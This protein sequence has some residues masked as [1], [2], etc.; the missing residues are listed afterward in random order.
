M[1]KGHV[2]SGYLSRAACRGRR[3]VPFSNYNGY[4][5]PVLLGRLLQDRGVARFIVAPDGYGKTSLAVEYAETMFSWT[6]VFW[7]AAQSPCFIRDLDSGDMA[8]AIAACDDK[9]A[10]AVFDD[11]PALS[12]ARAKAFSAVLDTLMKAGCEVLVTCRPACDTLAGLQRDRILL[13]ARDLL[14]DDD[15][16]DAARSADERLRQPSPQVTAVGRIPCLVWP[17]EGP[18]ARQQAHERFAGQALDDDL[19]NDFLLVVASCLVLGQGSREQLRPFAPMTDE[20]LEELLEDCPHVSFDSAFDRFETPAIAIDDLAV[21]LKKRLS[22]IARQS[23]FESSER[24]VCAWADALVARGNSDRACD[25]VRAAYP[26]N[27]N[28]D[29]LV[30]HAEELVRQACFMP[31]YRLLQL[32][33]RPKGENKRKLHALETL[34]RRML[35]DPEGALRRAKLCAFDEGAS[36]DVRVIGLVTVVKDG[37]GALDERAYSELERIAGLNAGSV[38]GKW[39]LLAQAQCNNRQGT[40]ALARWWRERQRTGTDASV[41]CIAAAWL[42]EGMGPTPEI[43]EQGCASAVRSCE[44]YVRERVAELSQRGLDFFTASAGLAVEEAHQRGMR[45]EGGPLEAASLM[46]LRDVEL[47]VLAQRRQFDEQ[48]RADQLARSDWAFGHPD[49]LLVRE[50]PAWDFKRERNVPILTLRLFGCFDASIG[51][52]PID[53]RLFSRRNTRSLLVVLAM[54]AGREVA[55]DAVVSAM[56][57]GRSLESGKKNF[58]AVWSNLRDALSLPD[59]TCPYLQRHQFGCSLDGNY[60]RS[61]VARL[62]EI[63]RELLFGVPDV[64]HWSMLFAEL[65]RDYSYELMPSERKNPL[66]N[67]ARIDYRNRI[68]DALVSATASIIDAGTPQWGIW[69]ARAALKHDDTREDAYVALMRAQIASNQRTAAMATFLKCRQVL[70]DRLGIDP[71]AEARDLYDSL[72]E[73]R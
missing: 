33:T 25:L 40:A 20:Q 59:G 10:L 19:P 66:V 64:G 48:L 9:A 17:S 11:V 23:P 7:L 37:G 12:P 67:Q 46:A 13:S 22:Q 4:A 3:P 31:V 36:I 21:A 32:N 38:D 69:F 34:C 51:G 72:L 58:Y 15:E 53:K 62:D 61:D 27:K 5:R 68:V 16:L 30:S 2:M 35:G 26:R 49:A 14:L 54:N 43:A 56:W 50:V 60:V 55:R 8:D 6:H 63:C 18:H 41:L 1:R 29:W 73:S 24:L 47:R 39:V 65:D 44:R 28:A 57:P 71:S 42:F 70:N 45:Y 52:V